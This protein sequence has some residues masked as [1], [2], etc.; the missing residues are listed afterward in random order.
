L[1]VEAQS[2][3]AHQI[4]R[5]VTLRAVGYPVA[6]VILHF[7]FPD[8]FMILDVRALDSLGCTGSRSYTP[9]FW[10]R[11]SAR[12]REIAG[13]LGVSLRTL[14]KALWEFSKRHPP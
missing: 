12:A 14:D 7:A 10:S 2:D 11:Y 6:S 1:I 3:E 9:A 8:R 5:L 4:A 13:R